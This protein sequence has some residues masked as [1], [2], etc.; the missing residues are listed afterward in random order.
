MLCDELAEGLGDDV[1]E[2]YS[3]KELEVVVRVRDFLE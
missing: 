2:D 3:S 1:G